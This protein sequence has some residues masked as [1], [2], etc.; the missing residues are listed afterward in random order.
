M[1]HT[2]RLSLVALAVAGAGGFVALDARQDPPK[3]KPLGLR[4]TAIDRPVT[5]FVIDLA[6]DGFQLTT[7]DQGVPFDIDGIG[8]KPTIGW[9][10]AGSDDGFLFLDTNGNGRVDSGLELMGDGLRRADGSRVVSGDDALTE[11]QHVARRQPGPVPPELAHVAY[12]DAQDE[13]FARLRFWT[14][15]NHNGVSEPDEL[16]TL[17][18]INLQKIYLGFMMARRTILETGNTRLV[19]GTVFLNPPADCRRQ[20][21]ERCEDLR[22]M[23]EFE[24]A[25]N[26]PLLAQHDFPYDA[27]PLQRLDI[28]TPQG[29]GFPTVVFVHGGSLSS[30]DKADTDYGKVCDAFP[31][32][33]IACAN[34]NYRLMPAVSWP[35]PVEDVAA[36]VAWVHNH[37]GERGGDPNRIF[38]LGHSSGAMLVARVGADASLLAKENV[39]PDFVRGVMPMGSIMWDDDLRQSVEK[40]GREQVA[41]GFARDPRGKSYGTLDAYESVWPIKYVRKGMPPFLFLIA[42][43]EQVNPPILKTNQQFIDDARAQ[44][45]QADL[46]IFSGRTHYSNIR[47]IHEPQDEVFMTVVEFI[48]KH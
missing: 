11:I 15:T 4:S 1:Q 17:P 34:V 2:L 14:D 3:F 38:L 5:T 31:A 28:V 26:P 40:N 20:P 44:G 36:A 46:K 22:P 39:T 21:D 13:V 23:G 25:R 27:D 10:A 33:G 18:S 41:A 43:R 8:R 19:M 32:A 42:E 29:K 9:T 24:F 12:V 6:K 45:N 30:G 35:A 47:Q 48:R 7:A 16:R 37:I